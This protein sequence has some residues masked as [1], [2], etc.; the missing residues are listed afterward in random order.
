MNQLNLKNQ[1]LRSR[2]YKSLKVIVR[3]LSTKDLLGIDIEFS[4]KRIL[5]EMSPE[6]NWNNSH[7]DHV[8]RSSS[9]D[10]TKDKSLRETF[11]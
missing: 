6:T 10:V 1:N 7:I 2:F 3:T 8:N 11:N 5:Y 4:G 9:F